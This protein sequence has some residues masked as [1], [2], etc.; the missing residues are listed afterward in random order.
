M[1]DSFSRSDEFNSP[2]LED[3]NGIRRGPVLRDNENSGATHNPSTCWRLGLRFAAIAE[4]MTRTGSG[5]LLTFRYDG[6]SRQS[7]LQ[8]LGEAAARA[9]EPTGCLGVT[10]PTACC[11]A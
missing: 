1:L 11:S 7:R 3:G 2:G 8:S 6:E 5:L 10:E 9:G 4:W